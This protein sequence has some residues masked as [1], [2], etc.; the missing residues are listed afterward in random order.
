MEHQSRIIPNLTGIMWFMF[1]DRMRLNP[2]QSRKSSKLVVAVNT[3]LFLSTAGEYLRPRGDDTTGREGS[4]K[5]VS[6]RL[7]VYRAMM[8]HHIPTRIQDL[9]IE[10]IETKAP[11]TLTVRDCDGNVVEL[12]RAPSTPL[13]HSDNTRSTI[14]PRR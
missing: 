10:Y 9:T 8:E 2:N 12:A 14:G 13:C 3:G 5:R 4:G 7:L 1:H 6:S 11:A